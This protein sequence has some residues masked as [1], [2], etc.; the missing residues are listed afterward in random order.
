MEEKKSLSKKEVAGKFTFIYQ[1]EKVNIQTNKQKNHF[2]FHHKWCFTILFPQQIFHLLTA[3]SFLWRYYGLL[4]KANVQDWHLAVPPAPAMQQVLRASA[5]PPFALRQHEKSKGDS[6][7]TSE[8]SVFVSRPCKRAQVTVLQ[9][10]LY[11]WSQSCYGSTSQSFLL[12]S[13]RI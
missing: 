3:P 11:A 13:L 1:W 2:C 4:W 5:F 8:P 9:L 6:E 10:H 7:A 12:I